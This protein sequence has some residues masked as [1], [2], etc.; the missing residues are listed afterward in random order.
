MISDIRSKSASSGEFAVQ[1]VDQAAIGCLCACVCVC[2]SDRPFMEE[3]RTE[4]NAYVNDG[5]DLIWIP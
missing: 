4:V 3:M 2:P 1:T 5:L